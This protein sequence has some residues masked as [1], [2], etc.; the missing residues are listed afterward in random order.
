[1]VKDLVVSLLW[2]RL[3]PGPGTSTCVGEAKIS[4]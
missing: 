2:L 1:M 3:I 4:K